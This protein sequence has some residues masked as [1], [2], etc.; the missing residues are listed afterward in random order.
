MATIGL[1]IESGA[2]HA[3]LFDID[4]DVVLASRI[5]KLDGDASD[6]VADVVSAMGAAAEGPT[7]NVDGAGLVYRHESERRAFQMAMQ[8]HDV[9]RA[10]MVSA[11][12]A[13][14]SWLSGSPELG[15][16]SCVLLYHLGS[17]GV[18]LSLA[19]AVSKTLTTPKTASLESLSPEHIGSTVPLAWSVIDEAGR[20][21]DAIALFGDRSDNRDLTDILALGLDTPVVR[22]ENATE[23]AAIG[24]ARLA[25]ASATR[26]DVES[27]GDADAVDDEPATSVV[28]DLASGRHEAGEP[29]VAAPPAADIEMATP[30][31]SEPEP[32][33]DAALT[34]SKRLVAGAWSRRAIPRRKHVST[35]ALLAALLSGGV[36]LAATLP[37]DEP[38]AEVI[39][40]DLA[41]TT[42]LIEPTPTE[43]PPIG[44]TPKEVAA[45]PPESIPDVP[46]PAP[47]PSIPSAPAI[48]EE[49]AAAV[50]TPAP[51]PESRMGMG[52]TE[53]LV[54]IPAG[55]IPP[56]AAV[57]PAPTVEPPQFTVPAVIPEPGKSPEQLEQEAWDRHWQQTAR[58]LQQEL[59]GN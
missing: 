12:E 31:L 16:S 7:A 36:A 46:K 32:P 9:E 28:D 21:P 33:G 49:G 55:S 38:S 59:I 24:A 54:P 42:Q 57:V 35:A 26:A 40:A 30:A 6:A 14:W 11:Q 47:L 41:R 48:A 3:V 5:E 56:A 22:V 50:T 53:A 43:N 23:L 8:G 27:P 19:D 37:T 17:A 52:V 18:C 15:S 4:A 45:A 2:I 39:E 10:E 20:T 13:F 29:S 51:A 58:W 44:S 34:R 25:S 1:S